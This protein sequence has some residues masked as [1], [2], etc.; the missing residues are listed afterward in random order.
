MAGVPLASA[1]E[2]YP[3]LIFEPDLGPTVS[4]YTTL[5]GDLASHGYIIIGVNPT[6][7]AS[8]IVFSDGRVAEQSASGNIPESAFASDA[9]QIGG[10]LVQVWAGDVRFAID[11]AQR[12][13]VDPDSPFV[14]RLDLM[15]I[16]VFGHSFGGAAAAEACHLNARCKA[17]ANLDGY[18]YGDVI[19]AGLRQPFLFL[20]SAG[21]DAD[22]AY[23]QLAVQ[24][25]DAIC[26]QLEI[27]YQATIQ[28]TRHFNFTDY[29]VE[30]S[31]A[32]KLLDM[33]GPIDGAHGLTISEA[34]VLTFFDAYL[35][36]GNSRRLHEL[37][38]EFPE[39]TF[40]ARG[41]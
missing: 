31:P 5:L 13:D 25:I 16:G 37:A 9:R 12:L 17:G 39:V 18:P 1:E 29:A 32:L 19:D 10:E 20:W 33:L 23:Y 27:G 2:T 21:N 8:T 15:H 22:N 7:G 36:G 6:Y 11:Q 28:G 3:V 14:G 35:K 4:D 38:T 34:Y 30:F 41:D 24:G 26:S 40:E